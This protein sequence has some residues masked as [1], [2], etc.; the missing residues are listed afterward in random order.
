M[1]HRAFFAILFAVSVWGMVP[2]FIRTLSVDL[3]PVDHL[4]IRYTLVCL[5]YLIG[6]AVMGGWRIEWRD[7][8]RSIMFLFIALLMLPIAV[9]YHPKNET[10]AG[11]R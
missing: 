3:G 7:W 2:V 5:A 4:V 11:S 6:L 10:L 1:N 9:Y 8:P